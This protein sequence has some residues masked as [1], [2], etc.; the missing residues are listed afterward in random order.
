MT[1]RRIPRPTNSLTDLRPARTYLS[2][3]MW[4]EMTDRAEKAGLSA[5][6]YL[7]TLIERD[8]VDADGRPVWAEPPTGGTETLPGMDLKPATAA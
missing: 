3:E 1:E 7:R 6:S 8:E 5:S 2:V 4:C